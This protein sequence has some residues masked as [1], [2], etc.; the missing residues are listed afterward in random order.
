MFQLF[1]ENGVYHNF[2]F[3]NKLIGRFRRKRE[4][5]RNFFSPLQMD[6]NSCPRRRKIKSGYENPATGFAIFP[7][8]MLMAV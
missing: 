3:L 4:L 2:C 8:D 7:Y 5:S 6:R 1:K